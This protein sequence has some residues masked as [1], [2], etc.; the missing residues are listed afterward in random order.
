LL[1]MRIKISNHSLFRSTVILLILCLNHCEV[2][3]VM[4]TQSIKKRFTM[5]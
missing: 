1:N 4:T 3:D 2:H 5:L